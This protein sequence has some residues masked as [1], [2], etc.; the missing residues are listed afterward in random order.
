MRNGSVVRDEYLDLIASPAL[1]ARVTSCGETAEQRTFS[2]VE[3]GSPA[4]LLRGEFASRG[5]DDIRRNMLPSLGHHTPCESVPID[6]DC[7]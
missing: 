1:Q 2:A 5:R 6:A 7:S 3:H 4:A